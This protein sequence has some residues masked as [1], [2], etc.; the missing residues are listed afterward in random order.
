MFMSV[1]HNISHVPGGRGRILN[2]KNTWI[3]LACHSFKNIWLSFSLCSKTGVVARPIRKVRDRSFLFAPSFCFCISC[4]GEGHTCLF[5][6]HIC[7]EAAWN[8]EF[9]NLGVNQQWATFRDGLRSTA[10]KAAGGGR[11]VLPTQ[12]MSGWMPEEAGKSWPSCSGDWH[13][14]AEQ[15]SQGCEEPSKWTRQLGGRVFQNT[16]QV[17]LSMKHKAPISS[18]NEVKRTV[19]ILSQ[20][21]LVATSSHF[22]NIDT[23]YES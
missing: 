3:R 6:F 21:D 5:G 23:C 19:W 11:K 7:K 10:P 4:L 2:R 13:T 16:W 18:S 14:P 17:A 12:L 15:G 22:P 8:M 20:L 1:W 9:E